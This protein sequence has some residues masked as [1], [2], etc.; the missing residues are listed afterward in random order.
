MERTRKC[1]LSL[2]NTALAQSLSALYRRVARS[3]AGWMVRSTGRI[4]WDLIR[5]APAFAHLPGY[6]ESAL[7][8]SR[9]AVG[10]PQ[11]R[12]GLGNQQADEGY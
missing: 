1:E 11:R 3:G 2:M 5:P 4:P 6:R 7:R 10:R 12:A 9:A 8:A